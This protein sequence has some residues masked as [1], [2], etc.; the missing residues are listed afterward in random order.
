MVKCESLRINMLRITH[1]RKSVNFPVTTLKVKIVF[2][3]E[4]DFVSEMVGVTLKPQ[5]KQL[6][7]LL[8]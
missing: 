3:R 7:L 2:P 6:R 1:T 5:R 8:K 4:L